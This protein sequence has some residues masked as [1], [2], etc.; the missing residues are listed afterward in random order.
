MLIQTRNSRKGHRAKVT[1]VGPEIAVFLDNVN[2]EIMNRESSVIA[3]LT[4]KIFQ[5]QMLS[6][7]MHVLMT[8]QSKC[9]WA[10]FAGKNPFCMFLSLVNC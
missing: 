3:L 1:F 5:F 2:S 9:K 6:F 10:V 4:G 7:D 8:D